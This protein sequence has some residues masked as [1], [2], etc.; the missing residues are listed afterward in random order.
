MTTK[1]KSRCIQVDNQFCPKVGKPCIED[2]C[3]AWVTVRTMSQWEYEA[4]CRADIPVMSRTTS[5][6]R[7]CALYKKDIPMC[8]ETEDV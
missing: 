4:Y 2:E 8:F 7:W 5:G 6:H 3:A 1:H